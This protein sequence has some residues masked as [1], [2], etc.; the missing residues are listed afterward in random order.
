[1]ANGDTRAYIKGTLAA[2]KPGVIASVELTATGVTA[3]DI[4][5]LSIEGVSPQTSVGDSFN[6]YSIIG[7][8]KVAIYANRP[9]TPAITVNMFVIEKT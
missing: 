1:M 3:T 8:N 4:V 6:I 5:L 2:S 9:Q 7:T